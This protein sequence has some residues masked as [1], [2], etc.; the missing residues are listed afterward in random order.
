MPTSRIIVS[1]TCAT[2]RTIGLVATMLAIFGGSLVGC[3]TSP[4]GEYRAGLFIHRAPDTTTGDCGTCVLNVAQIDFFD[5]APAGASLDLI[6]Q[7]LGIDS[8]NRVYVAI[9]SEYTTGTVHTV[10]VFRYTPETG[11][12][13]FLGDLRAVSRAQ[14]NLAADEPIVKVHTDIIEYQG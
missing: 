7:G 1:S 9:S 5:V 3:S 11:H 13:E 4:R 10:F 8:Q 6:W 14:G 12:K 2:M